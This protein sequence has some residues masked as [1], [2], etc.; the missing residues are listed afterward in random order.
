[1]RVSS[2]AHTAHATAATASVSPFDMRVAVIS[3]IHGNLHALEAVLADIDSQAPDEIWCLGD[4][5]GYGPRP[6]ECVALARE[7]AT[8]ALCGNHDLAVIGT[9][10]ISDFS[11]DAAA[12]VRWTQ[13]VLAPDARTWL[14]SLQPA[15]TRP[16]AEL[17]HGSPRDP[18]WD[19]VLSEE[20]AR[21]SLLETTAP[22]VLVGHS[23]VALAL[24]LGRRD[25]R[26]RARPGRHGGRAA[27]PALAPQPRLG[28]A[29]ARRRR[30]GRMVV[31]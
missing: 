11:G 8:V 17:F 3:D 7:R 2:H 26:G 16:G 19:Y 13:E 29:A 21:F 14:A 31:D 28:R 5:V 22:L 10:D 23:H 30:A 15:A 27:A 25:D 12:A 9:L 1:M 4:V 18:V 6:N 20:V 24:A